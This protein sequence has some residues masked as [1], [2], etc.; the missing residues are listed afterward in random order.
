MTSTETTAVKA[1][2][3]NL[4]DVRSMFRNET[5]FTASN[6]TLIGMTGPSVNTTTSASFGRL[7]HHH[8]TSQSYTVLFTVLSRG[9]VIGWTVRQND[10]T[11]SHIVAGSHGGK[12][13]LSA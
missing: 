5:E 7:Y 2:R 13:Y 3:V 9:T 4:A 11:V 6:G 12:D 1:K 10:D 8:K